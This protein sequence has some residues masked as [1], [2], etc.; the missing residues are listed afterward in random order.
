M[1]CRGSVLKTIASPW[2]GAW[3]LGLPVFA[4]LGFCSIN[5]HHLW[6]D[7]EGYVLI[8]LKGVL[9]G[10]PLY[11]SVYSQYGPFFYQVSGC[12]PDTAAAALDQLTDKGNVPEALRLAHIIGAA[13]MNGQ[14]GRRA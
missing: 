9:E 12:D 2:A 3:L 7:D 5:S 1:S 6:Y 4:V 14:S 8:A 10:E 11:T 13:I